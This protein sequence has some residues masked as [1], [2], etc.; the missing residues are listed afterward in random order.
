MTHRENVEQERQPGP[1]D[2][3]APKI[4]DQLD[5]HF[6]VVDLYDRER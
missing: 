6:R 3:G 5:V 2:H 4:V 1:P